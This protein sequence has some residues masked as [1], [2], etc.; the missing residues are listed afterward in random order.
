LAGYA[1]HASGMRPESFASTIVVIMAGGRLLAVGYTYATPL[2]LSLVIDAV[3]W[4]SARVQ[5]AAPS[6]AVENIARNPRRYRGTIA[7]LMAAFAMVLI[8]GSFVRSL[9]GS[10]LSWIDQTLSADFYVCAGPHLP[11]PSGPT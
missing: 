7:A 3:R 10:I 5:P 9:R 11:L 6:L 4:L 8:V 1:I 2:V